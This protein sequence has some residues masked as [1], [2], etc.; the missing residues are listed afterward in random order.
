MIRDQSVCSEFL[1]QKGKDRAYDRHMTTLVYAASRI[2]TS[3]PTEARRVVQFRKRRNRE[4]KEFISR[5]LLHRQQLTDLSEVGHRSPQTTRDKVLIHRS[6]PSSYHSPS[7]YKRPSIGPKKSQ[8][9]PQQL[10]KKPH[11]TN[12][13]E[14][15]VQIEKSLETDIYSVRFKDLPTTHKMQSDRS[16]Q[17]QK[18][19]S[20]P[21]ASRTRPSL[22][23]GTPISPLSSDRW[24]K[25][26]N[27][28]DDFP[29]AD[30]QNQN[31]LEPNLISVSGDEDQIDN[32]MSSTSSIG[33]SKVF[34]IDQIA[35]HNVD[36]SIVSANASNGN[37]KAS[38][39]GSNS[40]SDVSS[41]LNVKNS[42][43][44][45]QNTLN[46]TPPDSELEERNKT[47]VIEKRD[48]SQP[49]NTDLF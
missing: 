46:H 49:L 27:L 23:L 18:I 17:R 44:F 37:F 1:E 21:S 13:S 47:I 34:I 25:S 33:S 28:E 3:Q 8:S 39:K 31:C 14:K 29:Q 15:I 5:H 24:G 6:P 9:P 12:W 41:P 38:Q 7:A 48:R 43:N 32:P 30:E 4:K 26:P 16:K 11:P 22:I 19:E 42:L 40:F 20:S 45:G 35:V 36:E 10:K 2:D